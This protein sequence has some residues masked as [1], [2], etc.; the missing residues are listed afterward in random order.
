LLMKCKDG[1]AIDFKEL[2]CNAVHEEL[3]VFQPNQ[4]PILR[5]WVTTPAL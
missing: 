1:R 4:E 5:P 3:V 2:K